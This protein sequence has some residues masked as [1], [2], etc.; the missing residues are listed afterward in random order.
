M[1]NVVDDVVGSA[2]AFNCIGVDLQLIAQEDPA[3]AETI[4]RSAYMYHNR[5]NHSQ[6]P[7]SSL[8]TASL[9]KQRFSSLVT[10]SLLL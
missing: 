10:A 8:V 6:C 4:L 5:C 3:K 9:L 7:F 2:L 1:F